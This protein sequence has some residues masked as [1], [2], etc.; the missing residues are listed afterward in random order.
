MKTKKIQIRP[1][2]EGYKEFVDIGRKLSEGKKVKKRT[3][4]FFTSMDAVRKVLTENRI[5][6]MKVIKQRHPESL[7]ELAKLTGRDFKN[8]SQ[9]VS[10][11]EELG[12]V[13][14]K[15]STGARRQR[16]PVLLSDRVSVEFA[17]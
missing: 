9:D 11:L 13:D 10:F 16:R 17:I 1:L 5:R 15:K 6:L 14:L 7:Y 12:L 2:K 3:G 8:V 4:T